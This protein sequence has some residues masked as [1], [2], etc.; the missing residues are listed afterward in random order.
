MRL[1]GE[2][3]QGRAA[4]ERHR[5]ATMMAAGLVLGLTWACASGPD[6]ESSGI[7]GF[8]PTVKMVASTPTER[9]FVI[10]S[11]DVVVASRDRT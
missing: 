7:P 10:D 4:R 6:P 2:G 1:T 3:T 9:F 8:E 11:N 5:V